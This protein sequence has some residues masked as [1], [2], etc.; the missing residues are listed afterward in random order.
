MKGGHA[1]GD[2]EAELGRGHHDAE[3]R[4]GLGL[5]L[6]VAQYEPEPG[7]GRFVQREKCATPGGKEGV[8][9]GDSQVRGVSR[10]NPSLDSV[11][12]AHPNL[13]S[14]LNPSFSSHAVVAP[15]RPLSFFCNRFWSIFIAFRCID[16]FTSP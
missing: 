3:L 9:G 11:A 7:K 5:G 4:G 16:Y 1:E 12:A 10:P 14:S 13:D 15:L 6:G 2:H 8:A